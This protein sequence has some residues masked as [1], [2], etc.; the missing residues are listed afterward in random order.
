M[1]SKCKLINNIPPNADLALG[2]F[3]HRCHVSLHH[4]S[5]VLAAAVVTQKVERGRWHQELEIK[6]ME[7]IVI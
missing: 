2:L 4:F 6:N 1:L 7:A 5:G 3:S